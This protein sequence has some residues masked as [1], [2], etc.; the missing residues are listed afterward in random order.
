MRIFML[1]CAVALAPMLSVSTA[2]ARQLTQDEVVQKMVNKPITTRSFGVRVNLRFKSN[3]VLTAKS[4]LGNYT[5][6]WRR[7]PG[8]KICSTFPSG[9][10]KGTQC[11]TYT[12]L[13]NN[14]YRT[15]SGTTFRV[16]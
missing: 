1:A 12:D 4:L 8:N 16:N 13:G 14:R 11:N 10:A 7:G 2:D 15:S 5:G 3:G 9:P 6:A